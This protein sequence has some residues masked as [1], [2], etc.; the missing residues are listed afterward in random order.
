MK[1]NLP[2]NHGMGLRICSGG[3]GNTTYPTARIQKGLALFCDEQDLSEEAVGFGVPILKCGLQAIFPG[4]VDLFTDA[5][6]STPRIT[7]R[8]K[9]NLEEKISKNNTG[10]IDKQWLYASKN[11]LAAVIRNWPISR[12]VLTEISNL[13]RSTLGWKTN[14]EP[15][16]F[17]NFITMTYTV[18]K[19]KG[20]V[21]IEMI[22]TEYSLPNISEVIVM[23]EQGAQTFNLYQESGGSIHTGGDIGCWDLVLGDYAAFISS[24]QHISFSL[25]QVKGAR[26]Y[27]GRENIDSRLAWAGFGYIIPPDLTNFSYSITLNKLP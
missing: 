17:S 10:T 3:N 14:Y 6:I 23:N 4:E 7:A 5:G 8:Y 15:A 27:R 25:P 16:D 20:E 1:I 18:D 22:S 19:V 9:L 21:Y 11:M 2:F 13:L 24:T 26:L 12:R